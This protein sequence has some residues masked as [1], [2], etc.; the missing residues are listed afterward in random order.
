MK[1]LSVP[2][3]L[4]LLMGLSAAVTLLIAI[5]YDLIVQRSVK[6]STVLT[7][8]ATTG[9]KTG[10]DI[11]SRLASLESALQNLVRQKDPDEIEKQLVKLEEGHKATLATV[12]EQGEAGKAM[13]SAIQGLGEKQ[14]VV[15]EPLMLGN[16]GAAYE[17]LLSDYRPQFEAVLGQ[18]RLFQDEVQ[19]RTE[20]QL[21]EQHRQTRIGLAWR[22]GIVGTLI[23][24][25]VL[26]GW[27]IQRK[28]T[29]NLQTTTNKL[30]A[31]SV[32]LAAS[33]TQVSAS[34]R[35]LAEGANDQ[36]ASIEETSASL[37]EV[38]SMV[39]RNTENAL[40]AKTL[41]NDARQ[42]AEHG[43]T[44]MQAM[45][46]AMT[47]IQAGSDDINK[48]MK[49]IDEIAF[50]TNLLALNAA[51]EAA[52]AGEAGMGFAVVADEVRRLAQRSG[53]A[54]KETGEKIEGAIN[55]T[56]LGAEL[57]GKVAAALDDILEKVRQVDEHISQ[58]ATASSEQT[59][60][61]GQI[62][63]AVNTMDKV[64]Q[65]NAAEADASAVAAAQ[66]NEESKALELAVE[67]LGALVGGMNQEQRAKTEHSA[68]VKPVSRGKQ[69]APLPK[70][71]PAL[72]SARS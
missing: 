35:S 5:T 68:P 42:A 64:T 23:F 14:K 39:R 10:Y 71:S 27:V 49:T 52:R 58:V 54:S 47:A 31:A 72:A 57:T 11:L 9:L 2:R 16:G 3:Q 28:I 36:A 38:S 15:L 70:P 19:K 69:P 67:G 13:L 65:R 6:E 59:Q 24:L 45:S 53:Q 44:N 43:R 21:A 22:R 48:I 60:G 56:A 25:T 62:A 55:K 29:R 30:A 12:A 41:A 32:N 33:A 63:T 66:L 50:Q 61:I 26:A 17:K 51:V 40:Q 37:E 18:V 1:N 8:T 34:S 7:Q 20:T 46:Q 4:S